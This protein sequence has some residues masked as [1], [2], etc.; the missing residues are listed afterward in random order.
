[1]KKLG[2]LIAPVLFALGCGGV[3]DLLNGTD[4]GS[5]VCGGATIYQVQDK[6]YTQSGTSNPISTTCL[7]TT[8]DPVAARAQLEGVLRHLYNDGTGSLCIESVPAAGMQPTKIGCG[9][10]NCNKGTLTSLIA[11]SDANCTW[12]ADTSINVT[13]TARNTVS[14]MLTQ[15]RV[16]FGSVTAGSCKQTTPCTV[17]YSATLTAP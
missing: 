4:G 13:V 3:D 9:M 8:F 2:L 16:Q 6:N 5:L 10:V 11:Y 12:T 14:V 15:N 17:S 7:A 1:M